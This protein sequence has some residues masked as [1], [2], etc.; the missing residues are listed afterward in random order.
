MIASAVAAATWACGPLPLLN[1]Q[2]GTG[3]PAS[4]AAAPPP[5]H[6][7]PPPAQVAEPAVRTDADRLREASAKDAQDR[8]EYAVEQARVA[9]E[10]QTEAIAAAEKKI[11][12]HAAECA[13]DRSQ[14]VRAM[15]DAVREYRAQIAKYKAIR[16]WFQKHCGYADT[17]AVVAKRV[18][19]NTVVLRRAGAEMDLHCNA[20]APAG[21]TEEA[22]AELAAEN[23]ENDLVDARSAM[24]NE[25]CQAEDVGKTGLTLMLKQ[26][27]TPELLDKV[28]AY[29]PP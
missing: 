5:P 24:E 28:L 26:G 19:A 20:K 15:Q 11:S 2:T 17:R 21:Y 22:G 23:P 7:V 25:Q 12:E 13:A 18:D 27:S 6:A 4:N 29:S 10:R 14:R 3:A 9:G 1:I 8:A 16:P